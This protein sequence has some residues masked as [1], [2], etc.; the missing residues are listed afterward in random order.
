MNVTIVAIPT[1]SWPNS[2]TTT[3]FVSNKPNITSKSSSSS[4]S[5]SGGSGSLNLTSL[6]VS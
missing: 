4:S 6:S 5:S 2:T 3:K 1:L